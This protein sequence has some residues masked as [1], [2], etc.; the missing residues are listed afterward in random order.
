MNITHNKC[1]T[2]EWIVKRAK[3]IS[4]IVSKETLG[5][6]GR[7]RKHDFKVTYYFVPPSE[8]YSAEIDILKIEWYARNWGKDE[9]KSEIKVDKTYFEETLLDYHLQQH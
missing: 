3:P 5:S 6:D 8:G 9:F 7:I 4:D 2:P 1:P